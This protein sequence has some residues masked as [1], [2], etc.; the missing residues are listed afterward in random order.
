MSQ[1]LVFLLL[2]LALVLPMLGAV[3]LRLLAPRLP[4]PWLYGVA[5]LVFGAAI[6]SVLLLARA[7]VTSIQV[8][9]LSLLLPAAVRA[10]EAPPTEPTSGQL[11]APTTAAQQPAPGVVATEAA[12]TVAPTAIPTPAS[13]ITP[14]TAPTPALT[15]TPATTP[16]T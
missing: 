7:N 5:A 1:S 9:E 6:V 14:T 11:V 10:D 2:V 4:L 15:A 3:I 16:T 13:T 12:P 8:G